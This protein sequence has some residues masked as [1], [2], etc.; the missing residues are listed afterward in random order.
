MTNKHLPE[1]K[2]VASKHTQKQP[3]PEPALSTL[4]AK[5]NDVQPIGIWLPFLSSD[6][7]L[8]T[9]HHKPQAGFIGCPWATQATS[10]LIYHGSKGYV[11]NDWGAGLSLS[12]FGHLVVSG[13]MNVG[14]RGLLRPILDGSVK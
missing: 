9:R 5:V 3:L 11:Q 13:P 8:S 12:D 7:H 14:T 4:S 1:F 10:G 6:T 2:E